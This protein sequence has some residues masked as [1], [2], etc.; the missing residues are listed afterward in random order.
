MKA[1]DLARKIWEES[2]ISQKKLATKIGVKYQQT[3]LN[4]FNAKQGMRVDNFVKIMNALGY[5]VLIKDKVTDETTVVTAEVESCDTD[6][7]E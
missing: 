5:D 2:G 7:V 3:V 1:T 4:M 6:M